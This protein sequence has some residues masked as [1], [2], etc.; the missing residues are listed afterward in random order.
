M[1]VFVC[2]EKPSKEDLFVLNALCLSS[3]HHFGSQQTSCVCVLVHVK[4]FKPE[5]YSNLLD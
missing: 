3:C 5:K 1:L 2:Y 4:E